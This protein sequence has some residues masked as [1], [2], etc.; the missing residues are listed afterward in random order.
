MH[1]AVN[2]NYHVAKQE[3]QAFHFD[4]DGIIGNLIAP[5]LVTT[6]VL[7]EDL[8]TS[9]RALPRF[10]TEGLV[11]L[12]APSAVLEGVEPGTRDDRYGRE[13]EDLLRTRLGAAEVIAFDHTLRV[14]DAAALRKPA[15]NVHND[16]SQSG[17]EARLIDIVGEERAAVFHEDGYGF[18]NVWRPVEHTIRSSPLG[19]IRSATVAAEDWID[20][21][22]RYPDR[23]GQILGVLENPAHEWFYL[24]EMTPDEVVVFNIYDNR[25]RPQLAHS[26][27]DLHQQ[28]DTRYPRKSIE[29]RTVVRYG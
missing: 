2:V 13:I 6:P 3:P 15:R 29:T 19:F 8:R 10:D 20:I 11:F 1:T 9:D 22:L 26:A 24:S 17:A 4:A 14:D 25:G 27:L 5:E 12:E 23:I 21:Q 7:A 18:V 28:V 16:Y